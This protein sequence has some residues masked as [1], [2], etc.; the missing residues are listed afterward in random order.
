MFKILTLNKIAQAGLKIFDTDKYEVSNNIENPDGIILRSYSMHDM[1]LPENLL[2][3][4]RAGAGVNNIPVENAVKME[5]LF[6]IRPAQMQ[7]QELKIT[8]LLLSS[9]KIVDGIKWPSHDW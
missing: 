7:M 1:Q 5:L 8:G 4:A 6:L 2:A 9:R 3:I